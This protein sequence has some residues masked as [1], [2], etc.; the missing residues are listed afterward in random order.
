[1]SHEFKE[2]S[3]LWIDYD[4]VHEHARTLYERMQSRHLGSA[5]LIALGRGG[6][7]PARILAASFDEHDIP[8]QTVTIAANYCKLGSPSEDVVITQSLDDIALQRVK[9][10]VEQGFQ[11][12]LIDG[13]YLTGKSVEVAVIH[14]KQLFEAN[15]M[16]IEPLVG[17]LEWVQF[18]SCPDAPWRVQA[19]RVPDA[20]GRHF[21]LET[22]PYIEYPWEY[23][24]PWDANKR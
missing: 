23:S 24:L 13:P 16:Q 10:C 21:E 6:W 14:L 2:V 1:M 22:K 12:W 5:V 15:Q 19:E 9:E 18:K 4:D 7:V 11:P 3:R 17:V 8:A 20:Y